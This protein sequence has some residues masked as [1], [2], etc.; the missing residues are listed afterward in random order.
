MAYSENEQGSG[1]FGLATRTILSAGLLLSTILPVSSETQAISRA[2]ELNAVLVG[3]TN[4]IRNKLN[5]LRTLPHPNN[6]LI[7]GI[8][9]FPPRTIKRRGNL[10]YIQVLG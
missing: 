7:D 1:S 6:P 2:E 8:K 4:P 3:E 9:F 5:L 10:Q